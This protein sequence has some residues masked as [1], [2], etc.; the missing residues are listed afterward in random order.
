MVLPAYNEAANL[1]KAVFVTA[2]TL[3]KITDHFEIIIAEDGSTD[4]TDRIAS[5]LSEQYA[6]VV[7][8]HSD[9]RQGRGKALSRAFKSASGEVLCYID[10]DL[11]TDMKYLEKLVRAVST[12]GYD[13]ATGSRMM[14]ESDAK[15]PFKRE[16]AS[17]GYNFLVRLF[18]RS[19]LCDHQCGFK[20]FRREALF[21]L[22]D[23]IENEHWF[24]DTEVLVRAQHRGYKVIEFPV[25]WRH[26]GSSKVNLAKDVKGMGS[27]IFRL[28]RELSFPLFVSGR[29]KIFFTTGLAILILAFVATFLGTSD[30]LENIKHASFRT[31]VLASLVYCISWPLRGMRFQQ[32]LKRLGNQYG[33][34]FL[35]GSIFISQSANVILPAR[36]GD[37]SRMYILKKSKDLSLTTSFSSLTV[38]RVFDIVA[39]TSIAILA[40]SGAASHFELAP[41]M[42]SLIK[43]SGLAV[44]LFFSI[45]F[46][47][48]LRESH[49]KTTLE[50][51]K[52]QNGLSGKIKGFTSTFLHQM[53]VV[54]VRPSSFL[55]VTASSLL[56]WG[57]DIFT[58][59]LVLKSFQAVGVSLSS[60]YMISLIFLAVALGNIAK[61]FPVTP[62]AIGTYEV[63][64]TAVFAL[65]GI[66]PEIGFT[67]AVLDHIIKNS[68][69][70]IGG[71]FALSGLGLRWKEVLCT[72]KDILKG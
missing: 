71:G 31:L 18:L 58:C 47:A 9:K 40:S 20:A 43:L 35:T 46:I 72:D 14:C 57:I 15:R 64:L 8:M 11:A 3:Y 55:A 4:G 49:T 30:I 34:G 50:R 7:H 5:R 45:L 66:E 37:L 68:I 12:E 1:E 69:T 53:S 23:E 39:I 67:V 16:F 63:A 44:V 36:I 28:W 32:I 25:Y 22:L 29:G 6:Y 41:W 26:G 52:L 61:I 51:E 70:L 38:E 21:E 10:V 65:G 13:F 56:I 17:R 42:D 24:W 2:E 54:A 48:S 33:L 59:F 60:T 19:K 27:E 62:G